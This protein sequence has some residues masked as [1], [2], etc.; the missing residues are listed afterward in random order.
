MDVYNLMEECVSRN[1]IPADSYSQRNRELI[2]NMQSGDNEAFAELVLINGRLVV[3]IMKQYVPNYIY[4]DHA[5]DLFQQGLLGL[6]RAATTYDCDAPTVFSTYAYPWIRQCISRYIACNRLIR[7]PFNVTDKT[8]AVNR[9]IE[10]YK[11]EHMG[12]IPDDQTICKEVNISRKTLQDV[13]MSY[14]DAMSLDTVLCNSDG[15]S[16]ELLLMD[17][18]AAPNAEVDR[19]MLLDELRTLLLSLILK[20]TKGKQRDYNIVVKY[21]GLNGEE[22]VT[23]HKLGEI[24]GLSYERVRQIIA[25]VISK[26]GKPQNTVLLEEYRDI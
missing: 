9:F 3:N 14:G 8:I 21:F 10:K 23:L 16:R 6:Y 20:E 24:Y 15:E 7:V 2:R 4:Q 17:T 12:S 1:P 5:D 22:P 25:R 19:D 13:Y 18:V 11:A 26:L